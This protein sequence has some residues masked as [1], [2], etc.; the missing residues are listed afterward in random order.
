[1]KDLIRYSAKD[2]SVIYIYD[3][4]RQKR[5]FGLGDGTYF[6]FYQR[7]SLPVA[8]YKLSVSGKEGGFA[9]LNVNYLLEKGNFKSVDI[10]LE[11]L[12]E[13]SFDN[14]RRGFL[15]VDGIQF[16]T[17]VPLFLDYN[18]EYFYIFGLSKRKIA[19]RFKDSADRENMIHIQ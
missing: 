6:M 17:E 1:D 2:S 14:Y 9:R 7:S 18:S 12:G 19:F 8:V 13:M 16:S 15:T 10:V 11:D 5:I 3:D 4:G